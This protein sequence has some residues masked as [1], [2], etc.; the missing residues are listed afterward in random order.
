MR[1]KPSWLLLCKLLCRREYCTGKHSA[2]SIF[3]RHLIHLVLA[4]CVITCTGRRLAKIS[5]SLFLS[6]TFFAARGSAASNA[7]A[8]TIR[9]VFS[10]SCFD[11]HRSGGINGCTGRD[12]SMSSPDCL[13]SVFEPYWICLHRQGFGEPRSE[14]WFLRP[15]FR[16]TDCTGCHAKWTLPATRSQDFHVRNIELQQPTSCEEPSRKNQIVNS[17]IFIHPGRKSAKKNHDS[18]R[19]CPP[20][21]R[22]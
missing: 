8:E 7:W 21:N 14:Q 10:A 11:L 9:I 12:S 1:E 5:L 13:P 6:A 20:S 16:K 3:C 17:A 15:Y 19:L 22:R 2:M 18:L 4:F